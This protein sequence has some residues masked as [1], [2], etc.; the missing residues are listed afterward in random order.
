MAITFVKKII[1]EIAPSLKF[2][3]HRSLAGW[4]DARCHKTLHAS[5]MT[6]DEGFCPREFALHDAL[7]TKRRGQFI[8][9]SL[10]TTFD[11][12]D[13]LS[14]LVREKWAVHK[15]VGT[16]RCLKCGSLH[17]FCKY[18]KICNTKQLDPNGNVVS[19]CNSRVFRY[20]EEQFIVP[21]ISASGSLDM[22]YDAGLPKL[23]PV[24]LKSIDKDQFKALVAPHAEHSWRSNLYQRLIANSLHPQKDH[25]DQ[26]RMLVLY[27]CK[28]YGVK[29]ETI[30][31]AGIKDTEFSPFKEYWVQRDDKLTN[32][33]WKKA[34]ALK[35]YRS[36]EGGMPQGI[37]DNSYCK[38]AMSCSAL[39]PCWSGNY[40]IGAK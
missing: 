24:E 7:N 11:M 12:G 13:M 1:T 32:D 22:L 34:E 35:K 16:W 39:K 3:L 25:I 33:I 4:E 15:T 23:I 28:G 20:K 37:C 18:P 17:Q 26:K 38:R 31:P 2:E 9:T 36:K 8:G 5:D 30:K 27:V 6:R 21:S 14:D 29:D 10:R 40:P 19:T